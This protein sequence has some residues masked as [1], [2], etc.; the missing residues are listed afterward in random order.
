[1]DFDGSLENPV[2]TIRANDYTGVVDS[3]VP[4]TLTFDVT[5]TESGA[6]IR[7]KIMNIVLY[8]CSNEGAN[9]AF[10]NPG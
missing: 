4:F 6:P 1:M 8:D 9:L 2:L 10:V 5:E 7:E 3:T